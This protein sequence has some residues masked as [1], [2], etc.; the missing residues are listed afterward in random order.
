MAYHQPKPRAERVH[1]TVQDS[2]W[3]ALEDVVKLEAA[4]P[5]LEDDLAMVRQAI[6]LALSRLGMP[7]PHYP[8]V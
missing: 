5:E 3:E 1:D 7:H 6:Q 2:L 8:E 4:N